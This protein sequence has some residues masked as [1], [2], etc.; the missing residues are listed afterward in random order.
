MLP[1]LETLAQGLSVPGKLATSQSF[2][3]GTAQLCEESPLTMPKRQTDSVV[4]DPPIG[5]E[6]AMPG[7]TSMWTMTYIMEK[8]QGHR[9]NVF[10]HMSLPKRRVNKEKNSAH[11]SIDSMVAA[12][13]ARE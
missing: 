2:G 9:Y 3:I 8:M 5:C 4:A 12:T 6:S 7:W 11:R 1:P 13:P 10:V